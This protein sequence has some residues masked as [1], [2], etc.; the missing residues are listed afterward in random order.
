MNIGFP[1]TLEDILVWAMENATEDTNTGSYYA[2]LCH[3]NRC[4]MTSNQ[5]YRQVRAWFVRTLRFQGTVTSKYRPA[6]GYFQIRVA[7]IGVCTISS[8]QYH[9]IFGERA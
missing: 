9:A 2:R 6:S 3:I 8:T 1:E 7:G 5:V 4:E